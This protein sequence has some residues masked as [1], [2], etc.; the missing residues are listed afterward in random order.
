MRVARSIGQRRVRMTVSVPTTATN[1]DKMHL[2]SSGNV[3]TKTVNSQDHPRDVD[4]VYTR[5]R[6]YGM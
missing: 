5:Y 2:H 1:G 6:N 4:I 3:Q